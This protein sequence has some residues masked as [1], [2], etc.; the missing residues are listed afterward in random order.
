MKTLMFRSQIEEYC[1]TKL[2]LNDFTFT[3][4][5]VNVRG[6]VWLFNQNLRELPFHFNEV[7]GSFYCH[8]NRLTTLMGAPRIVTGDFMCNGNNLKSLQHCPKHVGGVF[9]AYENFII[10]LFYAPLTVGKDF[11]LRDNDIESLY[12]PFDIN[13]GGDVM[14]D[15]MDLPKEFSKVKNLDYRL[16]LKYQRHYEVWDAD[17]QFDPESFKLLVEEIKDGLL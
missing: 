10:N 14:I 7:D 2:R 12:H 6:D 9:Y 15:N 1:R 11:L 17:Q 4:D 8:K 5:G 16:F 3:P 13:V